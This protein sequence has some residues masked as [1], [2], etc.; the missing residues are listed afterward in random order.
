MP[1]IV[2]RLIEL[3]SAPTDTGPAD[4][5]TDVT[6]LQLRALN[7]LYLYVLGPRVPTLMAQNIWH[8]SHHYT[9]VYCL[10]KAL[11]FFVSSRIV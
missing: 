1:P 2:E 8:A 6:D 10:K 9:Q 4:S 7:S 3:V 11:Y 5:S